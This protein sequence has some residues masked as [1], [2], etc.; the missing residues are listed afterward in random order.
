MLVI[1][2]DPGRNM[3]YAVLQCDKNGNICIVEEGTWGDKKTNVHYDDRICILAARLLDFL[4]KYLYAQD[5][6]SAVV[7][8]SGYVGPNKTDSLKIAELRGMAKTIAWLNDLYFFEISP[9]EAKKAI[10]G[11]SKAE[12]KEVSLAVQ[13]RFCLSYAPDS[14]AADAVAVGVAH[15]EKIL[16]GIE[17]EQSR[18]KN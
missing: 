10:T 11:N 12:K 9:S 17:N 7:I 14:N 6:V 2:I 8:E 5:G 15:I 4:P 18:R 13:K 16:K 3:G 1:A